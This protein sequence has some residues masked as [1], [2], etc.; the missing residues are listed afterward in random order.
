MPAAHRAPEMLALQSS[1]VRCVTD[2]FFQQLNM[3]GYEF[4]TQS[5]HIIVMEIGNEK[6]S[7]LL[8]ADSS[9]AIS[10]VNYGRKFMHLLL[11]NLLG[12]LSHSRTV[13]VC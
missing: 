10:V 7:Y 13:R 5:R 9:S 6:I 3:S 4:E 2:F 8:M 1:A 12:G 11:G